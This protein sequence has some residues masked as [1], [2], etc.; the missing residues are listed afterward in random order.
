MMFK[1]EIRPPEKLKTVDEFQPY[2]GQ[3]RKKVKKVYRT[4]GLEK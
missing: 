4:I 2:M 3:R 1:R